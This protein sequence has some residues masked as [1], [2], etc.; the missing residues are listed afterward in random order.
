MKESDVIQIVACLDQYFVAP[1]GVMLYSACVNN[2]DVIIDF[3]LIVDE[4]VTGQDKNDLDDMVSTFQGKKVFFHMVNSQMIGRFPL[5]FSKRLPKAIYYRLFLTEILPLNMDKVLY[6]DGDC[7]VRHSLL[8][9]WNITLDDYAVGAATDWAEGDIDI[10]NRLRYSYEIGHFNTGVLLINLDYWRKH[11][12][13]KE[14]ADY[15]N[16]YPERIKFA[17]QDVMNAVLQRKRYAIPIKYN[18]QTGFLRKVALWDY[19]RYEKEVEEGKKDPVIVHF[20]ETF[21]PWHTY[22]P[23]RHPF[24]STFVKYQSQTKWKNYKIDRCSL[25]TKMIHFILNCVRKREVFIDI[26][27]ID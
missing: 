15:L 9:L 21:K 17:D 19:W 4:S 12:L 11:H 20:T 22:S 23:Y 2:P 18:F 3:H 14:Y 8:P 24:R 1:T 13:S 16:N 6:L 26:K 10:Y 27:P 7:I 25:K 5:K